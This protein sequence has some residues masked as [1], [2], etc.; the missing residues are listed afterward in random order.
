MCRANSS[1]GNMKE[2]V[3][4]NVSY[5]AVQIS[6]TDLTTNHHE[7]QNLNVYG[8]SL[9]T[10]HGIYL[11]TEFVDLVLI[12]GWCLFEAK[13]YKHTFYRMYTYSWYGST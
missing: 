5:S 13:V 9:I 8:I 1:S 7:V 10:C 4:K 2:L 12:Q 3:R 6:K 11:L